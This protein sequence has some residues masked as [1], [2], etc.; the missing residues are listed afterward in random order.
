MASI[1]A[2]TIKSM[3]SPIGKPSQT[4]N[5]PNSFFGHRKSLQFRSLRSFS[6][7]QRKSQSRKSFV[8]K[9]SSELPLVGN[10]ALDFEAEAVFDQEFINVKLPDYWEEIC[11]SLFLSIG[12][13]PTRLLLSVTE[14]AEFEKIN[15]EVFGVSVDSVLGGFRGGPRGSTDPPT[16][17]N[18]LLK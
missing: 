1:S 12:L 16:D 9:A 4:L 3:A 10:V 8:V 14:H 6:F 11:D 15:T 2:A 13:C 5:L 18:S 7:N 17:E